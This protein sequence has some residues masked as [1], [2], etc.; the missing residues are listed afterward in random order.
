MMKE[1]EPLS[2]EERLRELELLSLEEK[3]KAW[4]DL[5]SVYKYLKGG[6][7][8]DKARLFMVV[9]SNRPRDNETLVVSERWETLLLL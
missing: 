3:K 4:G 8:D 5:I 6:C 7:K 2:R 1:L 9:S